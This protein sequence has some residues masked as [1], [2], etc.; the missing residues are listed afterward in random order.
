[1]DCRA[2]A[3]ASVRK[4]GKEKEGQRNGM[5]GVLFYGSHFWPSCT[6]METKDISRVGH[7]GHLLLMLKKKN[8]TVS[9]FGQPN[10]LRI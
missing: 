1:M 3:H 6:K 4:K 10:V 5:G 7:Q 8:F 9:E 2:T